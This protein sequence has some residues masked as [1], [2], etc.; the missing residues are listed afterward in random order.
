MLIFQFIEQTSVSTDIKFK[1]FIFV[2]R[3][4]ITCSKCSVS[5]FT[6]TAKRLP[7]RDVNIDKIWAE[8]SLLTLYLCSDDIFRSGFRIWNG[9]MTSISI[10]QK[11]LKSSTGW[12]SGEKSSHSRMCMSSVDHSIV[13]PNC[14]T[15][16]TFDS[17]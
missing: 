10:S 5:S 4:L 2:P 1:I 12:A 11:L 14:G 8:A 15:F 17:Y 3:L 7:Q 6:L 13:S 9:I 16:F